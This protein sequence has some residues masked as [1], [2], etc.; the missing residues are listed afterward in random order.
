M[1]SEVFEKLLVSATV[2][3]TLSLWSSIK[4]LSNLLQA[5]EAAHKPSSVSRKA[6]RGHSS[7]SRSC[8]RD[9]AALPV[10]P[11]LTGDSKGPL[12][13]RNLFGLV[14]GGVF[15]AAP[16][17]RGTGELLPSAPEDG[18]AEADTFSPF[19]RKPGVVSL[20]VALSFPLPGLRVTERLALW[21]SD[22]PPAATGER[23]GRRPP[24]LLRLTYNKI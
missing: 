24:V 7:V 17:A 13:R 1:I 2:Q 23:C 14:P 20:S 11:P 21:N 3:K 19:P 5:A 22:F 15:Q 10:P 6:G 18:S 16:V 4:P 8:G 9:R 12:S